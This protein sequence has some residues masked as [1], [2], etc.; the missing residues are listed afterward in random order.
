[1]NERLPKVNKEWWCDDV[2][3]QNK[4]KTAVLLT[5]YTIRKRL[6]GKMLYNT[7]KTT[8]KNAIHPKETEIPKK[9]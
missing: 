5:D 3:N 2:G 6:P 9:R 8:R 7:R 1:M 4:Q